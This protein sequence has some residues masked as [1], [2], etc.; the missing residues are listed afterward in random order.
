MGFN[1]TASGGRAG[2][3]GNA[4][5]GSSDPRNS[6]NKGN[7]NT[8]SSWNAVDGWH[9]VS[10]ALTKESLTGN[11][12]MTTAH[13]WSDPTGVAREKAF[14]NAAKR[15]SRL[16]NEYKARQDFLS[17]NLPDVN[18][19]DVGTVRGIR[20]D[21]TD[22]VNYGDLESLRETYGLD[23]SGLSTS[24]KASGWI[25]GL[26]SSFGKEPDKVETQPG[27]AKDYL[28][29]GLVGYNDKGDLEL[30]TKG[31]MYGSMQALGVMPGFGSLSG[32]FGGAPN[33]TDISYK[34]IGNFMSGLAPMSVPHIGIDAAKA[35]AVGASPLGGMADLFD[36]S[37]DIETMGIAPG[38]Q[39]LFDLGF[40][41]KVNG[42]NQ[43]VYSSM[44]DRAEKMSTPNEF[45]GEG[46]GADQF[47][48]DPAK[49]QAMFNPV[50]QRP[51][52]SW[53]Y[54]QWWQTFHSNT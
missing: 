46:N 24:H 5:G 48:S 52:L 54:P 45:A 2:S 7:G 25:D 4:D 18:P 34:K 27:L 17:Q 47:F 14:Y 12:R 30:T 1:G 49:V 53:T 20:Q 32:L 8:H 36:Y 39:S 11:G 28:S 50:E 33:T 19:L 23:T 22:A 16:Q 13:G 40:D 26:F 15:Q 44:L 6:R 9:E 41:G 29:R 21:I 35:L 31:Q 43:D 38:G 51:G 3:M 42:Y 37:T 10:N